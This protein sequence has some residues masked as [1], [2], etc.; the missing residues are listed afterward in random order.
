MF[1]GFERGRVATSGADIAYVR[2]GSGPPL[3]L[4][5]QKPRPRAASP[6]PAE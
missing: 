2:G 3:L 4:L 6:A 5:L 1:D